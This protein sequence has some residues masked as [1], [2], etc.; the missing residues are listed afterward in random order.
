[1]D[2][3]EANSL[4]TALT[5]HTCSTPGPFLC[6]GDSD[7]C[8]KEAGACDKSGCGINPFSTGAKTYYG[9]GLTV[10]TAK[11]FTVVTQ[12][13]T[14]DGTPAG[15]LTEIRRLY[16]QGGRVIPNAGVSATTSVAS[17]YAA[18][19]ARRDTAAAP[20]AAA[21]GGAIT[22]DFCTA[23]NASSFLRL[24]GMAGMGGA[25][26][27]G[28][29]L[30]FS[31]WNSAGDFMN[32]LDSGS[33]GPCSNTSGDPALI[34]AGSPDVSVTFSNVRWGDIGSTFN[35]TGGPGGDVVVSAAKQ[36]SEGSGVAGMRGLAGVGWVGMAGVMGWFALFW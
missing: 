33:N 31:I 20:D 14:S 26:G 4:A 2:I 21:A 18:A 15:D 10:D 35:A 32:W 8:G 7:E 28:M 12:F 25:L 34:V 19:A 1:M 6:A 23:R 30:V 27:R 5:P 29:V 24:G 3:W 13:V 36:E 16:V 22:Q 9:P 11:P 17:Q